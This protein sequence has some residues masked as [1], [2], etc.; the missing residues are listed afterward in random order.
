MRTRFSFFVAMLAFGL[1]ACEGPAGPMGP[2]GPQGPQGETGSPGEIGPQGETGSPGEIG[3]QG[4]TGPPREG[5]II[6]RQ[7][8]R[9]LYD[10][11]GN[12]FIEDDRITPTTFQALYLKTTFLNLGSDAVAYIPLDYLIV[13]VVPLVPQEA[14]LET[15]LLAIVEGGLAIVDPNRVLLTAALEDEDEVDV[16]L[17]ILVSQ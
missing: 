14:E 16:D 9:S 11:D 4:E 2:V 6:E 7:L 13:F 15:P 1:V 10:A 3:P 17:A 12:I 5:V 8:S